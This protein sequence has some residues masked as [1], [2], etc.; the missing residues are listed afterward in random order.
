MWYSHGRQFTE[1]QHIYH[2]D[3]RASQTLQLSALTQC[4]SHAILWAA[5]LVAGMFFLYWFSTLW[6]KVKPFAVL[7]L[8][9]YYRPEQIINGTPDWWLNITVLLAV[10]AVTFGPALLIFERRDLTR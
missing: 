4:G 9:Y 3:K 5:G 10:S 7:S 2:R 6:D 8:F 1:A